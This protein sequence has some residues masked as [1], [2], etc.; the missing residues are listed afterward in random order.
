[1]NKSNISTAHTPQTAGS[2]RGRIRLRRESIRAL[3]HQEMAVV[4]G[5]AGTDRSDK[6]QLQT[7]CR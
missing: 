4:A 7:G 6:P 2:E 5:G 1:M 3:T